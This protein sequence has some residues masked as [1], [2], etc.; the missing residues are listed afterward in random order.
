MASSRLQALASALIRVRRGE[1][2][3]VLIMFLYQAC[4]VATFMVGRTTRDTLFL[5]RVDVKLLPLMY[6]AVSLA[7]ALASFAYSRIADSYRR[8]HLI[9]LTLVTF[10]SLFA[11]LYAC[12]VFGLGGR[13]LYATLY[14]VVE[15]TGAISMIQFWTLAGDVFSAREG[16]RLFGLIGAGGVLANVVGGLLIGSL[17]NRVGAE[18]LIP[19]SSVL[20]LTSAVLVRRATRG[21]EIHL[22][23]SVKRPAHRRPSSHGRSAYDTHDT[24]LRVVAALVVVT[25][26]VVT[27]VDFQ[28]KT[29]AQSHFATD[30]SMA[31]W[32]GYFYAATGVVAGFVQFFLTGR[33]LERGGVV[34]ALSLLPFALLLSSTTL[35]AIPMSMML[36][37]VTVAKGSENVFR[38]TIHEASMQLLCVPV[39]SDRRG[40]AKAFIDGVLK[41]S[42]IALVGL[43]LLGATHLM[44]TQA[45]MRPISALTLPLLLLWGAMI[46]RA[47][48]SYVASLLQTLRQRRFDEDTP[49]RP[50]TDEDTIRLVSGLLRSDDEATLLNALD[51]IPS[52]GGRF[53]HELSAL[54]DHASPNVRTGALRLLAAQGSAHT[55]TLTTLLAAPEPEVRAAALAAVSVASPS[56]IARVSAPYMTD[57]S[58]LVRASAAVSVLLN[59]PLPGEPRATKARAVLDS[60][61]HDTDPTQRIAL[62][63]GLELARDFAT[64]SPVAGSSSNATLDTG[65]LAELHERLIA[66]THDRAPHVRV[67]AIET[68]G[69]LGVVEAALPLLEHLTD[70]GSARACIRV[71]TRL[72]ARIVEPLLL[73]HLKDGPLLELPAES[74]MGSLE[75]LER[76]GGNEALAFIL[77]LLAT[78]LNPKLHP[79]VLAGGVLESAVKAAAAIRDRTEKLDLETAPLEARIADM[80][81]A[82]YE[83]WLIIDDLRLP[84]TDLLVEALFERARQELR[85]V[86]RLLEIRYASRPLRMI[87]DSLN[88]SHPVTLA[89]VAE[90]VDNVLP[91]EVASLV[92]PLVEDAGSGDRARVAVSELGLVSKSQTARLKLLVQSPTPWIASCALF[93]IGQLK[94]RSFG[95]LVS[96]Q[97]Q[98][99]SALVRETADLVLA[100]LAEGGELRLMPGAEDGPTSD[101]GLR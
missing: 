75:V 20:F 82:T 15:A 78:P 24:H 22:E 67:A 63:R 17:A 86:F 50:A 33:L 5:R 11:G 45:L 16:R 23:R 43:F 41:P 31:A 2:R 36:V 89:N 21:R 8:D 70:R 65:A 84:P 49:W 27:L 97:F 83:T 28:F 68:I 74:V 98:S 101:V 81:R 58:P 59:P 66:L 7:V 4:L 85:V 76:I 91:K 39:P 80:I 42:S 92:L 51:L 87:H 1:R 64:L 79:E 10:A 55:G 56:S 3:L 18:A 6:V 9:S 32:F 12:L 62:L 93:A 71:L 53:S 34:V 40:Q 72:D 25:F 57:E 13:W 19:T 46:L 60:L 44:P 48:K 100:K 30:E 61:Q 94:L 54:L 29:T 95:V 69:R 14:V 73:A 26:I 52:I 47:R 99:K 37:G 35:L 88:T 77:S 38:Y 96:N 90:I